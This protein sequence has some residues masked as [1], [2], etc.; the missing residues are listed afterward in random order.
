MIRIIYVS[1]TLLVLTEEICIIK[2]YV[3]LIPLHR[4]E[5]WS[6]EKIQ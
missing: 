6:L 1:C 4:G 2:K 3:L 5:N